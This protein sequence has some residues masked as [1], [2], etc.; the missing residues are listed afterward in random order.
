M[1]YDLSINEYAHF[2]IEAYYQHLY[3]IP[4]VDKTSFSFINLQ[5]DW[6]FNSKLQNSGSGRNY[7]L[8]LTMEKYL[9]RGFYFM[10]TA[11]SGGVGESSIGRI[12][13]GKPIDVM[14]E[15]ECEVYL[16]K[17][18]EEEDYDTAELIRKRME[19]FR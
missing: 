18:L 6:F 9:E 1:S 19:K 15:I 3:S 12:Y 17:A 7:G 13:N 11:F 2:K 8:D 14:S 4:V 16:K 10:I 5:A